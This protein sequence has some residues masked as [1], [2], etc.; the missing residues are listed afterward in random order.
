MRVVYIERQTGPFSREVAALIARHL[1]KAAP[2][3][4]ASIARRY[5]VEHSAVPHAYV[6]AIC[7]PQLLARPD[8]AFDW[9]RV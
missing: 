2:D 3:V 9:S 8:A 7:G 5:R 6:A 1:A 4:A